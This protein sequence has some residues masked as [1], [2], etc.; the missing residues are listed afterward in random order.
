MD[1]ARCEGFSSGGD[2]TEG[3]DLPVQ[4]RRR[5]SILFFDE[6]I[7]RLMGTARSSAMTSSARWTGL[8]IGTNIT[9]EPTVK[10]AV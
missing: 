2:P 7:R 1:W 10:L 5:I 3:E 4:K 8:C 6:S 9:E